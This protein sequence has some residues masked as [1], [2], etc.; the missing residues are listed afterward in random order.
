MIENPEG[1]TFGD[2]AYGHGW[3]DGKGGGDHRTVSYIEAR[4]VPHF[5]KV[6]DNAGVDAI[7]QNATPQGMGGKQLSDRPSPKNTADISPLQAPAQF[8]HGL[9]YLPEEPPACTMTPF[10]IDGSVAKL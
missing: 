8:L 9:L 2:R 4:I 6:I 1:R 3:V 5:T 7:A 10:N